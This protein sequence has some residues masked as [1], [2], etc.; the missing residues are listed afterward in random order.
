[1]EKDGVTLTKVDTWHVGIKGY[2]R[3]Y[4]ELHRDKTSSFLS[5][6]FFN[7]QKDSIECN[8]EILLPELLSFGSFSSSKIQSYHSFFRVS[9]SSSFGSM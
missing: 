6:F 1:M 5:F 4:T 8:G 9:S 7:S 3:L 2:Y